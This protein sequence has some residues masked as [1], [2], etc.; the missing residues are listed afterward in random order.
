MRS[1]AAAYEW[2]DFAP[3]ERVLTKVDP[4]TFDRYVGTYKFDDG[5]PT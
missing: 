4:G 3:P 5:G 1:I 2:P